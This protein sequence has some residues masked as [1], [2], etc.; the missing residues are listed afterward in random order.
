MKF[1]PRISR[2]FVA[3]AFAIISVSATGS[4]QSK[5]AAMEAAANQ[6]VPSTIS[7]VKL[8]LLDGAPAVEITSDHPIIPTITKLEDPLRL[9]VD[10]ADLEKTTLTTTTGESGHPLSSH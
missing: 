4:A 6:T 1:L 3:L 7:K 2:K 5:R 10:F 8:T 9:V